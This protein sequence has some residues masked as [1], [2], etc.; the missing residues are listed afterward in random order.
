MMNIFYTRCMCRPGAT[1]VFLMTV[2]LAGWMPSVFAAEDHAQHRHVMPSASGSGASSR[3]EE[4][5]DTM[6]P[7]KP[8]AGTLNTYPAPT[9]A[10]MAAAFPDLGGMSMQDHMGGASYGKILLDRLEAQDADVSTALVWDA[11]A[12]WGSALNRLW[13]SSEGEHADGTRAHLE[14]R[15]Y[16]SHAFSR[17]W[18]ATAG[19]RQDGGNGPD[20]IWAGVGVQGLAPCFFELEASAWVGEEGRSAL[21]L[22]AEYALRLSNRLILQPRLAINAY[23]KD[24]VEKGIGSGLSDADFGL[25]LRYEIR[26]KIAPYAGVEWSRRFGDTADMASAHGERSGDVR[27]L[28]GIRF[29]F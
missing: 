27:A 4:E 10:A 28:A 22:A 23:G 29:W 19:L 21:A 6:T 17:W 7:E 14:S 5:A 12:S 25:R 11:R 15:L 20:R 26:R 9:A 1:V 24:D 2:L 3:A 18:E 16:G 8:A 13:F